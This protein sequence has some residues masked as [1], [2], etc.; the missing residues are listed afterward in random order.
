MNYAYL[1][2]NNNVVVGTRAVEIGKT[3]DEYNALTEKEQQ[4]CVEQAAWEFADVYPEERDDRVSIIV[5]LGYVGCDTEVDTDIST[6]EEW[7]ELDATE[8]NFI[9]REA[10][11]EAVDC[12]VVFEP[13]DTEAE[14]HCAWGGKR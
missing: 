10:F 8:V 2:I 11:W 9:L 6:L 14:K 12:Y 13:N 7:D 5:S 3:E 1:I 4:Y